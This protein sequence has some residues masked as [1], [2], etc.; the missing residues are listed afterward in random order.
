MQQS[1]ANGFVPLC[2]AV[3]CMG[4]HESIELGLRRADGFQQRR[5]SLWD[6]YLDDRAATVEMRAVCG[7]G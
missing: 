4:S 2:L 1:S 3:A 5:F 7:D 6:R